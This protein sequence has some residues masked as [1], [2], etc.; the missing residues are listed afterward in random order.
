[1]ERLYTM[2][3]AAELFS[4]R[5]SFI[6]AEIANGNLRH[7]RLGSRKMVRIRESALEEWI[8]S[9]EHSNGESTGLASEE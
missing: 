7:L 6:R 8:T 9:K 1:M 2:E 5:P 4:V 3:E